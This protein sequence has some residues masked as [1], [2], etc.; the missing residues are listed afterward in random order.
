MLPTE[1]G[2]LE[3]PP[4]LGGPE[5]A[6]AC[7]NKQ[8]AG[9]KRPRRALHRNA[10]DALRAVRSIS[11]SGKIITLDAGASDADVEKAIRAG[12][13]STARPPT[14]AFLLRWLQSR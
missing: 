10:N 2:I 5:S 11:I 14:E 3:S 8:R 4:P 9:E 12:V 6:Q 13:A 1:T 7:R